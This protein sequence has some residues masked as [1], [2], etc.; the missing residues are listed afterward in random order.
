MSIE[1]LTEFEQGQ[2]GERQTLPDRYLGLSETEMTERI[3]AAR[4]AL[5][6]R[7]LI[8]G[9]HYQRDEVIQ[10]ADLTGDSFKAG[11]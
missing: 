2:I 7:L 10:F 3:A 5:G 9:H 6:G 8:L 11:L 1:A 4:A